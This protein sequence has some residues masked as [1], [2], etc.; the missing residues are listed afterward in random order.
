MLAGLEYCKTQP[1][2]FQG[3]YCKGCEVLS[4]IPINCNRCLISSVKQSLK[5]KYVVVQSDLQDPC[6]CK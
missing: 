4:A 5:S 1:K 2:S 3:I 6:S